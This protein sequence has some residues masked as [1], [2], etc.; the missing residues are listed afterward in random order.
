[1]R[2]AVFDPK[3]PKQTVSITV[4]SELYAMAKDMGI[5][6]SQV[7]EQALAETYATRH[8]ARITA[9]LKQDLAAME[10]YEK[11]HGSFA[12]SVREHYER[13]DGAI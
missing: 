9:E 5:N 13:E 7:A 1:M 3:G 11:Q 12:E 8:A 10:E 2:R 6:T 4:N